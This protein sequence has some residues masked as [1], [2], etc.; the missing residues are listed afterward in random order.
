VRQVVTE[1]NGTF[2]VSPMPVG[3]FDFKWEK[4]GYV[5]RFES[6]VRVGAGKVVRRRVKMKGI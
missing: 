3:N 5:M 4:E 1:R 6:D 2:K